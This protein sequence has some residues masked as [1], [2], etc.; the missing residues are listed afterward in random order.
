MPSSSVITDEAADCCSNKRQLPLVLRFVDD[1]NVIREHIILCD[2]DIKG[3][4]IAAAKILEA[5]EVY[6]L[7]ARARAVAKPMIRQVIWRE[8]IKVLLL[9]FNPLF[10]KIHCAPH[11]FNLCVVAAC[12]M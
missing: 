9:T 11:A 1:D 2:S 8:N 6:G 4:S 5:L 10:P 12:N 3:H 7:D